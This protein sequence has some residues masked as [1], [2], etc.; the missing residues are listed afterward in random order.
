MAR[1]LGVGLWLAVHDFESGRGGSFSPSDKK[2]IGFA[3]PFLSIEV[4]DCN[5]SIFDV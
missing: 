2:I 4:V 3:H 5:W 1:A